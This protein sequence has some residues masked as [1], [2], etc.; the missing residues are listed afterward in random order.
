MNLRMSE[1]SS[2]TRDRLRE[3]HL[4]VAER[5]LLV[6]IDTAAELVGRDARGRLRE[7][8]LDELA[9]M[10]CMPEPSSP[11]WRLVTEAAL[12]RLAL[13]PTELHSSQLQ[14]RNPRDGKRSQ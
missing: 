8:W 3:Q 2:G 13:Q 12:R 4:S 5:E 11:K 14:S 9:C 6:F 1:S 10:D 7:I